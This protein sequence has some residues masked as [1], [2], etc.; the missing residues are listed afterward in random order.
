MSRFW[1]YVIAFVIALLAF[2]STTSTQTQETASPRI[3]QPEQTPEPSAPPKKFLKRSV[4][5]IRNRYIVVLVDSVVSDKEPI[6]V[7]RAKVTAIASSHA[8]TY[9]GKYDYIYETA[10]KGY[11]IELPNEAAAIAI[12]NLPEVRFVE[13]DSIGEFDIPIG[14]ALQPGEQTCRGKSIPVSVLN[15]SGVRYSE[16]RLTSVLHGGIAERSRLVI[17]DRDAFKKL[18]DQIVGVQSDKQP[19]PDVDF[20]REILVVAA[21]GERPSGGFEIIVDRACEVDNHLEVF[22]RSVD[23]SSC[24]MQ[25]QVLTAPVDIVRIPRTELSV[26]FRETEVSHCKEPSR[27]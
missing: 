17:R 1:I 8:Q 16:P 15:V 27:P 22:V 23:F 19:L 12:S 25:V 18:W 10:L 26:V 24:G 11:A 2:P 5:T 14:T 6:E 20:S 4:R 7:R 21:M 13:E 3:A 9:G